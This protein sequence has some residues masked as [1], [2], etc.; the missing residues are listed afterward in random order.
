MLYEVITLS[1][2]AMGFSIVLFEGA[3]STWSFRRPSESHL[4]APLSQVMVAL[5][6]AYLLLRG[7]DLTLRGAWG[8]AFA[9]DLK[10]NMFWLEQL[11]FAVPLFVV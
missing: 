9:G 10:G 1:A 11:L 8:P 6:V 3:L 7:V 4:L 5:L 2:L